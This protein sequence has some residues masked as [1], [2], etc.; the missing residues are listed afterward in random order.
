MVMHACAVQTLLREAGIPFI[1][2]PANIDER[3][4]ERDLNLKSADQI[5]QT[6]AQTKA[7]SVSKHFKD[8]L[9]LGADQVASCDGRIFGKAENIS[10]ARELLFSLSGRRH[11]LHSALCL[12]Q[13]DRIIFQALAHADLHVRHITS[14]FIDTY[15]EEMEDKILSSAGGYQIEALGAQLFSSIEGDHWTIMGLPILPLLEA[16]RNEGALIS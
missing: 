4:I 10:Q 5:A 15:I 11:R 6:L 16:L 8:R 9:V 14:D 1:I 3:E 12:A 7:L 13:N 2:Q